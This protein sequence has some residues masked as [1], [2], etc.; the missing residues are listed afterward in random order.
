MIGREIF[1]HTE[2]FEWLN[3]MK[4]KQVEGFSNVIFSGVTTSWM[5]NTLND[6]L[7]H[8]F[9]LSGIYNISSQPI[10]KYDLITKLSR[11]FNLNIDIIKNINI[12]SNKVLNSK[13]F[14]EITGINCP[15]WDTLIDQFVEDNNNYISLYKN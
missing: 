2:L 13:K 4:D 9:D 3:S 14:T 7:K 1:N 11:A 15:S 8:N 5:G 6:I 12:K 10:S